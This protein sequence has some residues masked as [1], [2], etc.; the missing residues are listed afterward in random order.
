M[1][2]MSAEHS[3]LRMGADQRLTLEAL[4]KSLISVSGHSVKKL[5]DGIDIAF[6]EIHIGS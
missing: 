6:S 1:Y 5:P 4:K 2:E 3:I